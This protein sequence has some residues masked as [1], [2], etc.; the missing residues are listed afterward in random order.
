MNYVTDD[1]KNDNPMKRYFLYIFLLGCLAGCREYIAQEYE[2]DPRL[3]FYNTNYGQHDSIAQTFFLLPEEQMRDTVWVDI[4]TMGYPADYD[5]QI[6]LKQ[7]NTDSLGAAI[8]GTHYIAFDDPQVRERMII[9]AGEIKAM[10]PVILLKDKSILASKVRL[11]LAFGE[12]E[13]FCPGID[14]WNKFVITSTAA[15]VKPDNWDTS[16]IGTFGAWGSEKMKF[17]IDYVGY[18]EFDQ[19]PS[20]AGYLNFLK[21]KAKQKLFEFN[22]QPDNPKAP[23]READGTFVEF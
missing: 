15:A 20:D 21:A 22:H 14:E 23:L 9:P 2:N 10:I 18:T 11:E 17:I 5:R 4:R 6:V 19:K 8:V 3:Y 13:Y 7:T 1:Y 16:W 12:M